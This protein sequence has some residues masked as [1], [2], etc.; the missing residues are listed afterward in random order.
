MGKEKKQ[1]HV[2]PEDYHWVVFGVGAGM[3]LMLMVGAFLIVRIFDGMWT[4]WQ[5]P[6]SMVIVFFIIVSVAALVL[7]LVTIKQ[8]MRAYERSKPKNKTS[9]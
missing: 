4:S 3:L 9:K 8:D 2:R 1:Q 6:A 5:L 7:S